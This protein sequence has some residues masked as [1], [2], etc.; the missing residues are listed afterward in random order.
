MKM[1]VNFQSTFDTEFRYFCGL[2]M[3]EPLTCFR[4]SAIT[5]NRGSGLTSS[6][7]LLQ[8]LKRVSTKIVGRIYFMVV[9]LI[10]FEDSSRPL[11]IKIVDAPRFDKFR[12]AYIVSREL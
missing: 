3:E 4:S 12:T 6:F 7:S 11:L 1:I 10:V 2:I 9:L 5:V 8:E